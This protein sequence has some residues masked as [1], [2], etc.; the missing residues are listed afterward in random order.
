MVQPPNPYVAGL[1]LWEERGFFGR[2]KLLDWVTQSLCNPDANVLVLF[3]Q[4]RIGKTSLLL[5][6]QRALSTNA[7][8]PIYFDLQDQ[9]ARP[10]G[11][12]LVDLANTVA[13]QVGMEPPDPETFDNR[14]HFFRSV[15]L[16]QVYEHL[17]ET[18]RPVFLLDEFD[19]LNETTEAELLM[20]AA[21][22]ALFRF[23]RRLTTKDS[24][25]AFVF[26][27]GRRV[28]DLS[29]DFTA[30]FR[31]SLVRE[32]WVLDQE[33]AEALVR[34]AEIP[35]QNVTLLFTDRAVARILSLTSGHPYLTQLLCRQIWERAYTHPQHSTTLPMIDA[36]E[37]EAAVPDALEAGNQALT[38]LWDGLGLAEQIYAAGLAETMSEGES[39][40]EERGIQILAARAARLLTRKIELAP[41][42]L[43]RRRVLEMTGE[44]EYGFAVEILR[45]WVHENKP[46]QRMKNK[47]DQID[48]LAEQ[49]FNIGQEF[50][51]RHQWETAIRYFHDALE[52][53]PRHFHARLHLGETLLEAGRTDE[54]TVELERAYKLD[55]EETRTLLVRALVAQAR[56]RQEAGDENGTLAAC[57]RALQISPKEQAVQEIHNAIRLRRLA[58]EAKRYEQ[59]EQWVKAIDAYDQLTAQAADDKSRAVWQAALERCQKEGQLTDLF[60]EGTEALNQRNWQQAQRAFAEIVHTRPDYRV[61]GQLA[62]QLLLQAVRR[63]PER[64][65]SRSIALTFIAILVVLFGAIYFQPWRNDQDLPPVTLPE[66][67]EHINTYRFD[68]NRDGNQEWVV[69]Y[70]FDLSAEPGQDDGPI[71]GVVYQP[72]GSPPVL[73]P[74]ELRP[75]DGDYLCECECIASLEN[76][77]SG[78]QGPELV[79]RDRCDG[80]STR[81]SIFR[82]DTGEG[83]YL[84]KGH[85]SGDRITLATDRATVVQ[86]L[87]G[88]AQLALQYIYRPRDNATYYQP[89]GQGIVKMHEEYETIF[90]HGMPQDVM[91]S[92]YP[93][94]VVLASYNAYT[95]AVETARY[96]TPEAW[97][98]VEGCAANQCGCTL[99]REQ[100]E[101]VRMI[102]VQFEGQDAEQAIVNVTVVCEHKDGTLDAQTSLKWRLAREGENGRF[103]LVGVER[104]GDQ[105]TP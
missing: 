54:A 36:S 95:D 10:L 56:A 25:S 66:N 50:L 17:G 101:H 80:E 12:V 44:R 7:F 19:V 74:Y 105:E 2:Q 39:I 78:L 59:A 68:T 92:P 87:P 49:L 84:P 62:T 4:R 16:P 52:T 93:E 88:R 18:R 86:R 33:S 27:V 100:I 98:Q 3:G 22:K 14:G 6:L 40:T 69:L 15:F 81:V 77:L 53:N 30:T 9:A 55:Q 73:T 102:D 61:N 41:R 82:W 58:A 65:F 91:L 57:E 13:E 1:P 96:F 23:I 72:S 46:L 70:R 51:R 34:Q 42:D 29:L 48:P 104:N 63:K 24:R 43:V 20:T 60:D 28:E 79:I 38:W 8:L 75:Q 85:F 64:K 83:K 76:V 21:T 35:N 94:K 67:W 32:V 45:R 31:A 90:Y 26:A 5:Q 89:G 37:V 97:A 99:D 71:A 11:R 103:K 47:L